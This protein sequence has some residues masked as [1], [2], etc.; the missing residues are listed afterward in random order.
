VDAETRCRMLEKIKKYQDQWESMPDG[1]KQIAELIAVREALQSEILDDDGMMIS[2]WDYAIN[3]E[4]EVLSAETGFARDTDEDPEDV[5]HS[6]TAT[7]LCIALLCT[8][9]EN[10]ITK[11]RW[12]WRVSAYGPRV[13]EVCAAL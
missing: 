3:R 9:Q 6:P 12:T 11:Y 8:C 4:M 2:L 5:R 1:A 13:D 10:L 7:L